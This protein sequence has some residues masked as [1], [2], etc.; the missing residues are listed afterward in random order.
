MNEQQTERYLRTVRFRLFLP[1]LIVPI[2]TL[3]FRL[4]GG[5]VITDN[6]QNQ[7]SGL[8]MQLP[9]PRIAT[10]SAKDKMSFYAAAAYD[11]S[12]RS[13]ALR[14]DPYRKDT[15]IIN[16]ISPINKTVQAANEPDLIANKIA[17]IQRQI[18]VSKKQESLHPE[19]TPTVSKA[20]TPDPEMEAINGMIDKLAAIQQP[21]KKNKIAVNEDDNKVASIPPDDDGYFGKRDSV[22]GK[23]FLNEGKNNVKNKNSFAASIPVTQILQTGSVVK[24]QLQQSL[25]VSGSTIASGS[26][27][28][29]TASLDNE[30][31]VVHIASVRSGNEVIPVS[32]SVYDMDGLEGI[33]VPGSLARETMKST[34][35][36]AL[37]SVNV[38]SPEQSIG[39]QAAIAGIGAAKNLLSK[40]V[41]VIRVTVTAGYRVLLHENKSN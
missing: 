30:R 32:L 2:V 24:L 7:K 41:K 18:A 27:L 9:E 39:A 31:L 20:F 34:A 11:S 6:S 15:T 12:K 14:N 17:A 16:S 10:D 40:K 35:D 26:F 19:N 38:L 25:Q 1:V 23:Q 4:M 29:G 13:E 5:G 33:Y 36:Q 3:S 21:V 37:Q 28:F 22:T 8:N